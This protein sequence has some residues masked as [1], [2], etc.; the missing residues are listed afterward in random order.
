MQNNINI[1]ATA[2]CSRILYPPVQ[3]ALLADQRTVNQ[4]K[5]QDFTGRVCL[6]RE[7]DLTLAKLINLGMMSS[8]AIEFIADYLDKT[9]RILMRDHKINL[10]FAPEFNLDTSNFVY[11]LSVQNDDAYLAYLIR[12]LQ[13]VLNAHE[14]PNTYVAP[15]GLDP[16]VQ[17]LDARDNTICEI[18]F[19][20]SM[21]YILLGETDDDIEPCGSDVYATCLNTKYDIDYLNKI[22]N[23]IRPFMSEK[24]KED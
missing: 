6:K 23:I 13:Q 18:R 8:A 24:E 15:S 20:N 21:P 19:E 10:Q 14:I 2:V 7:Y 1:E 4:Q 5:L 12:I 11:S 22:M 3:K 9:C 17:V 16:Y